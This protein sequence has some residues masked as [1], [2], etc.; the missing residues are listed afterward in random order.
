MEKFM[1]QKKIEEGVKLILDGIGEDL[2][3]E[4]IKDT[5]LRVARMYSEIFEGMIVQP[6]LNVGFTEEISQ[7]NYI[8]IK[9]IPFYSFCEHHL[10]P[11]FG[12]IKILYI[13]KDNRVAGF[14]DLIKVVDLFSRRLQIQERLT[15]Q[16]ADKLMEQLNPVGLRVLIEATQLCVTMRG[17]RAQGT[18]TVTWAIRGDI[19]IEKMPNEFL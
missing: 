8:F 3:R 7:D 11:F 15:N 10:L 2:N 4:G 14:S 5:P 13:P 19:S 6:D 1:D 16:I 12:K 9:D 17:Q 18:K